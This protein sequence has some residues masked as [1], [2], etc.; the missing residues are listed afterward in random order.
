MPAS[1]K[2]IVARILLTDS[3]DKPQTPCP[4]VHPPAILVPTPTA[5]PAKIITKTFSVNFVC[6]LIDVDTKSTWLKRDGAKNKP[7]KKIVVFD[8]NCFLPVSARKL[9]KIPDAPITFPKSKRYRAP[10][11]PIIRP[12][13][14]PFI[15][16]I[17]I[18]Q[19]FL[20]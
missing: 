5:S 20:I 1:T 9:P 15:Q 4:D 14:R 7:N 16:S 11:V 6:G 8:R 17:E 10:A 18:S 12:P 2:T 13:M 3:L 19:S